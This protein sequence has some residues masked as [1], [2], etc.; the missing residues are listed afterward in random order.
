MV[1]MA[2]IYN[3][4][5][6]KELKDGAKIQQAVDR[7]P[8]EIAEKVIPVMEVNPKLL[9]TI[10]IIKNVYGTATGNL[11][12][13]SVPSNKDFYLVG[14][15]I[16]AQEDALSTNTATY[17]A[18]TI[19]GA[20]VRILQLSKLTLTADSKNGSISFNT[21][22]KIDRGTNITLSNSFGAGAAVKTCTIYGYVIDNS[23]A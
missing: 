8:N 11:T 9:R 22:I 23:N 21:P 18:A 19:D 17:I 2:K 6:F 7:I 20:A 12:V 16:S 1:F 13:Y 3:S 5:L 10:N 15:D 4:D 14:A